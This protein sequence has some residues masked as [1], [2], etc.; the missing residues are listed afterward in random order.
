MIDTV[1]AEFV[2]LVGE[3]KWKILPCS[4]R[5]KESFICGLT[6]TPASCV[7][8]SMGSQE[9][10]SFHRSSE[11]SVVCSGPCENGC[12]KQSRKSLQ[13]LEQPTTFVISHSIRTEGI[14][15]MFWTPQG[16]CSRWCSFI[17][18][19]SEAC[20]WICFSF[21]CLLSHPAAPPFL[22]GGQLISQYFKI[23]VHF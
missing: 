13:T 2:F 20:D 3:V 9:K 8:N 6:P 4:P 17:H 21:L 19:T 15:Y 1:T 14:S 23:W 11:I 7:S 12:G 10:K 16:R 5:V 22:V 18:V